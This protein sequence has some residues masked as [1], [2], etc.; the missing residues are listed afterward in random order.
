MTDF[1]TRLYERDEEV[2]ANCIAR[3]RCLRSVPAIIT[4]EQNQLL[5]QETTIEEIKKAIE[6]LPTHKAPGEDRLPTEFFQEFAELTSPGL[7]AL[8][9]EMKNIGVLHPSIKKGKVALIPKPGNLQLVT[10]YR[11]I[12][13]LDSAYKI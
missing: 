10:N 5:T 6:Q 12:T 4:E 9:T 8:A 7:A 2:E 13:L 1:Y 11:P 3:R